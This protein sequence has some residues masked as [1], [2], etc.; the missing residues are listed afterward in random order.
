MTGQELKTEMDRQGLKPIDFMSTFGVS[1]Q[2][3]SYWV[4]DHKPIPAYVKVWLETRDMI[5]ASAVV[6]EFKRRR[7]KPQNIEETK[8]GLLYVWLFCNQ[9]VCELRYGRDSI[10]KEHGDILLSHQRPFQNT[11][12]FEDIA[13]FIVG[14]NPGA[15]TLL[16]MDLPD[17]GAI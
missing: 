11:H 7:L 12:D 15:D 4:N 17:P 3:V 14:E 13:Q 6:S 2:I 10:I 16:N 8:H 9:Y 1:K 5:S